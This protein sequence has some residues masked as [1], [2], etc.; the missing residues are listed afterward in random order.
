MLASCG[1]SDS[2]SDSGASQ[3]GKIGSTEV[4]LLSQTGLSFSGTSLKG[5]GN[6]VAK[7]PLGEPKDDRNI[8]LTFALEDGGSLSVRAFATKTLESGVKFTFSRKGKVLQA[9]LSA[10]EKSVDVSRNFSALDASEEVSVLL[11]VHN[12]ETPAHVLVWKGDTQSPGDENALFNS[13]KAGDG[14]SAGNGKGTFWGLVLS[15][16]TIKSA[17]ASDSKFKHGQ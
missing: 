12:N 15:K 17:V 7:K 5:T 3:E 4:L 9:T 1:G 10:D 11:D 14:E 6:V 16:A 8:G 13:E 2:A